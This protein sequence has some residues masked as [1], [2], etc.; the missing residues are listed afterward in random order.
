[1]SFFVRFLVSSRYTKFLLYLVIVTFTF[2]KSAFVYIVYIEQNTAIYT[3]V[4]DLDIKLWGAFTFMEIFQ[5]V[6]I[7]STFCWNLQD[8]LEF[9]ISSDPS[10]KRNVL[11]PQY[12]KYLGMQ[13]SQLLVTIY[14]LKIYWHDMKLKLTL[15]Y[16]LKNEACQWL[17]VK[18]I[19]VCKLCTALYLNL[20]RSSFN[21]IVCVKVEISR[22]K[23]HTRK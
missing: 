19:L 14:Y 3:P 21:S 4:Y 22:K 6:N 5:F 7:Q 10:F 23:S 20:L 11:T 2:F 9:L 1:M 17:F 12:L 13:R 18:I 16:S 8:G 15:G